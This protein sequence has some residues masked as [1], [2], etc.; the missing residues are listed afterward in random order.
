MVSNTNPLKIIN[1]RGKNRFLLYGCAFMALV[2]FFLFV[3]LG[4]TVAL[5]VFVKNNSDKL[6]ESTPTSTSCGAG[7]ESLIPGVKMLPDINGKLGHEQHLSRTEPSH[8]CGKDSG[9]C[10]TIGGGAFAP[11]TTEQERYYFNTQWGGFDWSPTAQR[12]LGPVLIHTQKAA[13]IRKELPHKKL[14]VTSKETGKSM[15][16]SAEESGPALWVTK[17]L[18]GNHGCGVRYGAPPEVY[19]YLGTSNPYTNNENDGK[20]EVTVMYAKDQKVKLGPCK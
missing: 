16:V 7:I 14:I 18:F 2:I 10:E 20:G 12:N 4:G 8:Y 17:C 9:S 15:V 5:A 6:S 19:K 3:A 13:K 1:P 11:H